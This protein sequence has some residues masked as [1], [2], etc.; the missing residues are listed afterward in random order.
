MKTKIDHILKREINKRNR[1]NIINVF[2]D[3]INT[4]NSDGMERS[5]DQ[6]T[7]FSLKFV[8]ELYFTSK[9]KFWARPIE[10]VRAKVI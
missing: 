5:K 9:I 1:N 8:S 3:S 2:K 10:K 6:T 7:K 4:I